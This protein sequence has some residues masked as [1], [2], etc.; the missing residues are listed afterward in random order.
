[1]IGAYRNRHRALALGGAGAIGRAAWAYW[2]G[3]HHARA[4]NS[5]WGDNDQPESAAIPRALVS[6][7]NPAPRHRRM[8]H[9]YAV[10]NT[11]DLTAD[12]TK[13]ELTVLADNVRDCYL[14]PG[15]DDTKPA[16]GY[17]A[18]AQ[19]YNSYVVVG[20]KIAVKL[21]KD[22]LTPD[23]IWGRIIL[24]DSLVDSDAQTAALSD[25]PTIS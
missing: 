6:P 12:Q 5:Q 7:W 10:S 11:L 23:N 15:D 24:H 2:R 1:M 13:I 9:R 22:T 14:H 16:A 3:L 25:N 8:K 18:M 21:I 19:L 20:A 17:T 4:R